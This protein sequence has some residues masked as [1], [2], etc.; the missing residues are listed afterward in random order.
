MSEDIS[1]QQEVGAQSGETG[2]G[3]LLTFI[4]DTATEDHRATAREDPRRGQGQGPVRTLDT[5]QSHPR[6]SSLP[7]AAAVLPIPPFSGEGVLLCFPE[8]LPGYRLGWGGGLVLR[9][10][11]PLSKKPHLILV[12]TNHHPEL[13]TVLVNAETPS[14]LTGPRGADRKDACGY[15]DARSMWFTGNREWGSRQA[16]FLLHVQLSLKILKKHFPFH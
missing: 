3:W 11:I 15:V 12:K 9:E 4:P 13:K 14:Q 16:A 1:L 6:A 10:G 5:S 7:R 8:T 2:E